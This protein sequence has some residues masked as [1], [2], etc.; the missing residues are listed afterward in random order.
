MSHVCCD[1]FLFYPKNNEVVQH[2]VSA[3]EHINYHTKVC[4]A[5][6]CVIQ[7][8]TSHL[9]FDSTDGH[10]EEPAMRRIPRRVVQT[11]LEDEPDSALTQHIVQ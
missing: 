10:T 7:A 8:E 1:G 9:P 4:F 11:T 3:F 2:V 6:R 5:V